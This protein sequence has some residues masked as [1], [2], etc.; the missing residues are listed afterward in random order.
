MALEFLSCVQTRFR[1]V[2]NIN[3]KAKQVIC[4]GSLYLKKGLLSILSCRQDSKNLARFAH[5]KPA[6]SKFA[7]SGLAVHERKI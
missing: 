4:L 1:L 5:A 3:V 7:Y 2:T 6:L